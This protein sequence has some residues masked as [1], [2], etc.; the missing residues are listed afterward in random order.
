MWGVPIIKS[1]LHISCFLQELK[2]PRSVTCNFLRLSEK[3]KKKALIFYLIVFLDFFYNNEIIPYVNM[4]VKLK[5]TYKIIIYLWQFLITDDVTSQTKNWQKWLVCEYFSSSTFSI[6][7]F[8]T[9]VLLFIYTCLY[10]FEIKVY[11][12]N[13]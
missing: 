13:Y 12:F 7:F 1:R 4:S 3:E 11:Y 2:P 6:P 10:E 8:M 9:S 5:F